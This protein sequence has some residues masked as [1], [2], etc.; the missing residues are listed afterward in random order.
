[1]I[2][3]HSPKSSKRLNYLIYVRMDSSTFTEAD[4][5]WKLGYDDKKRFSVQWT[6]FAVI[7]VWRCRK[8]INVTVQAIRGGKCDVTISLSLHSAPSNIIYGEISHRKEK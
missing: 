5:V 3:V 4:S 8:S 2:E 6:K 7:Y 1:M